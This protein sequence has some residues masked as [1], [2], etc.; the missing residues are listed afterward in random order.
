[1]ASEPQIGYNSWEGS[2]RRFTW[3]R[4]NTRVRKTGRTQ[5]PRNSSL[6]RP[7]AAFLDASSTALPSLPRQPCPG[8]RRCRCSPSRASARYDLPGPSLPR[9]PLARGATRR[10]QSLQDFCPFR[11]KRARSGDRQPLGTNSRPP[12]RMSPN[13]R[14]PRIS[15]ARPANPDRPR[16]PRRPPPARAPCGRALLAAG[17]RI[18]SIA[19]GPPG[20]ASRLTNPCR[21]RVCRSEPGAWRTAGGRGRPG[22]RR[23]RK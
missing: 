8:C 21:R 13:A 3:V 23:G 18:A 19:H 4:P 22:W 17:A 1:V 11:P 2:E 12:A 10:T 5:R 20:T 14:L 15:S 6:F 7:D 16:Y 9:L